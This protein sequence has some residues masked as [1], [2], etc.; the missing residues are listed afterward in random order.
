ME[1]SLS[2]QGILFG[3]FG[4]YRKLVDQ[5]V[6]SLNAKQF[7]FIYLTLTLPC[8]PKHET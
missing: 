6:E 4:F 1:E 5:S 7:L 8:Y 3:L 2:D